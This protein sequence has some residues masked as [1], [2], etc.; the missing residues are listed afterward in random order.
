MT[1][2][3]CEKL[4]KIYKENSENKD[5]SSV[6]REQSRKNYEMMKTHI[7]KGRKFR[8]TDLQKSLMFKKPE[9]KKVEK[10][11]G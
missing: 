4:L 11:K 6:A 3:N 8:G 2:D 1:V 10:P 9:V 7:L 5:L